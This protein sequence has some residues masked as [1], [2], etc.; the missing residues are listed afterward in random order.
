MNRK[1]NKSFLITTVMALFL[2]A[3][4]LF[5]M[6]CSEQHTTAKMCGSGCAKSCCSLNTDTACSTNCT[7]TCCIAK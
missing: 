1:A 4:A 6:G 7:K 5:V 2:G 3:G